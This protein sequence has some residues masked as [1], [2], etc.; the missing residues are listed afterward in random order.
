[1]TTDLNIPRAKL[2]LPRGQIL[3]LNPFLKARPHLCVCS[4]GQSI[5][6]SFLIYFSL[7]GFISNVA[8]RLTSPLIPRRGL[9]SP[10]W[11][12]LCSLTFSTTLT[13]LWLHLSSGLGVYLS[14]SP[15]SRES[16]HRQN[17]PP[18]SPTTMCY[19]LFKIFMRDACIYF[20]FLLKDSD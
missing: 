15:F 5:R 12:Y 3:L 17:Q 8:S 11:P 19:N 7:P 9:H 14:P 13:G 20:N 4:Y 16:F 10:P 1:M 2:M 6:Y 18:S